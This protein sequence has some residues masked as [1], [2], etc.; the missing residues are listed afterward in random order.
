MAQ[1]LSSAHAGQARDRIDGPAKVSGQAKYASDVAVANPAY[2]VFAASAIARGRIAQLDLSAARAVPGVIE[3]LTHENMKGAVKE[4]SF[5]ND[6]GYASTTIRP[7]EGPE[8]H[9]DGQIIAMV[10]AE[11]F[12]AAREAA[13]RVEAAYDPEPPAASFDSPGAETQTLA[14]LSEDHEDPVTGD[15]ARAL[16]DAPVTINA[17][18]STPA[19]HHN[20]IELFTTTCAWSGDELIVFEPSQTVHGL[21]HGLAEQLG[22]PAEKIR[23]TNPL[24][25]GAFGS[26]GSITPRTALVAIGAQRINRPVKL[27]TTRDQGFTVATYRAETRHR[28]RLGAERDGKLIALSHEGWEVTSRP[29]AYYVAGTDTTTRLYACPNISSKV[30]IVRCDRNTPGFMRSPPEV[31]YVYALESALDELAVALEMDPVELRRRNDTQTE[32]IK[33]LPYTSRSLMACFDAAAAEFGWKDRNPL[34]SSMRD[35]DWLIGWGCATA[36]YPT[37][38]APAAARVTLWREGKVRVETAAHDI[39]TGAYTAIAETAAR[40]LGVP[41]E[42]VTVAL[43]DTRLPPAPVA[44]GSNTTASVCSVVAKACG[45]IRGRLGWPAAPAGGATGS[46]LG[47]SFDRLN[48]STLEEYAE[49]TPHGVDA[50]GLDALRKGQSKLAG[51]ARLKDRIQYAFGAEFVEVRIHALTREIRVPRAIGAFAGG[52]IVNPKT[53]HSQLM[54]GMIWGIASALHEATEVDRK[55][56]RYVNDNLADYLVPVNAD[57]EEVKVLMLPE[58]DDQINPLGIKGLG[59]L[60]N[61][62][63]AAAVANAVYHATGRRIRDLPIRIEKLLA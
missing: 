24:V 39:G 9:H 5:F 23:V 63:T 6:Q 14:D 59:E 27:V 55:T 57:I 12:E 54:G 33:G 35:G 52:Y 1:S 32:P 30:H 46:E 43:G 53:A 45:A 47:A 25:G 56:A 2:A 50:S 48:V 29:D 18:Y 22:V 7:L 10:L 16:A 34:P 3:I 44:G 58:E 40:F 8:I 15:A 37:L 20:P 60:G 4:P 38:V 36:T 42:D 61:V 62:G 21:Q 28:L 26:K 11:S 17:S 13:Y 49:F 31:P 41:I 19:Q 51:G